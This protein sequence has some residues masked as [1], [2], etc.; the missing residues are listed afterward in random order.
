MMQRVQQAQNRKLGLILI[1]AFTAMF[2]GAIVYVLLYQR[3]LGG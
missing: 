3:V 1:S 2:V